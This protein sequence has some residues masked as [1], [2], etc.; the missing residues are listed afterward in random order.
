[1]KYNG[2]LNEL[3]LNVQRNITERISN[4]ATVDKKAFSRE[5]QKLRG[6]HNEK[7]VIKSCAKIYIRI[8]HKRSCRLVFFSR[9]PSP[10]C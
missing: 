3:L 1:M 6:K 10:T 2:E 5:Y 4:N 9:K 7:V 8:R